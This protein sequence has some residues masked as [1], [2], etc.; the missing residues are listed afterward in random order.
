MKPIDLD[1]KNMRENYN[2]NGKELREAL[3]RKPEDSLDD[4][5]DNLCLPIIVRGD[6]DTEFTDKEWED[7]C[8]DINSDD[9]LFNEIDN[10]LAYYLNKMES[11]RKRKT[12]SNEVTPHL[13]TIDVFIES[14]NN[15]KLRVTDDDYDKIQKASKDGK[16]E[17]EIIDS[18]I[19][20]NVLH[21]I[22]EEIYAARYLD[23]T[24]DSEGDIDIDTNNNNIPIEIDDR[25][26]PSN[27]DSVNSKKWRQVAYRLDKKK[28]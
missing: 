7:F 1:F 28:I 8:Q 14:Y 6:F 3:G 19:S 21:L 20:K 22:D 24:L 13:H 16:I 25:L 11:D 12:E 15:L 27:T 26:S 2:L 10:S 18:I 9:G 5:K 17:A 4:Y 23:V